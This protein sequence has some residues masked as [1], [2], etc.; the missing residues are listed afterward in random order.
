MGEVG[1]VGKVA[2]RR[3]GDT[4]DRADAALGKVEELRGDLKP[5]LDHASGVAKQVDDAAPLFLDCEFNADCLF[6]RYVGASKGIERAALNFGQMS[7][8]VQNALPA[9]LATWQGI[10]HFGASVA[11]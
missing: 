8:D 10:D 7:T 9:S 6:N 5:I 11:Q 4:L 3:I 1:D 2:D